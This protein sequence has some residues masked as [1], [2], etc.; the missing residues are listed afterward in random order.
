MRNLLRLSFLLM[1]FV[2]FQF[3]SC[4]KEEIEIIEDTIQEEGTITVDSSL[5]NLLFRVSLNDGNNDDFIDG[6]SCFS[7]KFPFSVLVNETEITVESENDYQ[8]IID[9]IT[10][11]GSTLADINISY[12]ISIKP[13]HFLSTPFHVH[14]LTPK[15]E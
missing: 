11:S 6:S 2:V 4:Q 15:H 7:I 9:F 14:K 5:T 8:N 1:L 12:P 10:T 3:T 13:F